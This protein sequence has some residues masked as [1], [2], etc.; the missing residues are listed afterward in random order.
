MMWVG[1]GGERQ[2]RYSNNHTDPS[3]CS[4]VQRSEVSPRSPEVAASG[5][6][7]HYLAVASEAEEVLSCVR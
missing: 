6:G 4:N 5:R 2:F 3:S 1:G 7:R